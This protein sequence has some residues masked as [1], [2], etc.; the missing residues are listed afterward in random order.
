MISDWPL[1]QSVCCFMLRPKLTVSSTHYSKRQIFVQKFNFYKTPTFSRV[2]HPI[3]FDNFS[4]EIKVVNSYK[5]QKHNIF[6]SFSSKKSTIFT[7]NQSWIFGQKN[8]DFEQCAAIIK[9]TFRTPS[10]C[11][12]AENFVSD[13]QLLQYCFSRSNTENWKAAETISQSKKK[14]CSSTALSSGNPIWPFDLG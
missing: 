6:T 13:W 1:N 14:F 12:T 8:E 7:G 5:V 3:F 4:R 9:C 11:Q 10:G 2:F